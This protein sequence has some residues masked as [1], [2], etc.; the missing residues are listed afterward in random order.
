MST[1]INWTSY[2]NSTS[3]NICIIR[4]KHN[5]FVS[6]ECFGIFP[7]INFCV[8]SISQLCCV[9]LFCLKVYW[10]ASGNVSFIMHAFKYAI[11]IHGTLTRFNAFSSSAVSLVILAW[12]MT[13][14][15]SVNFSKCFVSRSFLEENRCIIQSFGNWLKCYAYSG[16]LIILPSPASSNV[17]NWLFFDVRKITLNGANTPTRVD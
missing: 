11:L 7:S 12:H 17:I 8:C 15:A 1:C 2:N 6:S 5:G 4:K 16:I 13:C 9:Q 14:V 3:Q 10:L